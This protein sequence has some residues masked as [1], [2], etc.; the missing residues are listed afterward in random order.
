M[1]QWKQLVGPQGEGAAGASLIVTEL[2]LIDTGGQMLDHRSDLA[3]EKSR[4]LNVLEQGN[5]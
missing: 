4:L 1:M 5:H 2:D 3:A